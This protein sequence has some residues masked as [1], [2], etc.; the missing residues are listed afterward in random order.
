MIELNNFTN[1]QIK[2]RFLKEAVKKVLEKEGKKNFYISI[3][4][5]NLKEIARINKKYRFKEAPTDVLS[6]NWEETGDEDS[7]EIIICPDQV[8]KNSG[9]N[10]EGFVREL[11]RVLVHGVLH[12]LGYDHE[13]SKKEDRKMKEKEKEYISLIFNIRNLTPKTCSGKK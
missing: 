9:G 13:K 1:Y 6:F 5:V 11:T 8:K 10:K 3:A 4:L 2:E 12:L 7:G